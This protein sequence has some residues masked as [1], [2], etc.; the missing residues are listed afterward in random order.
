MFKKIIEFCIDAPMIVLFLAL[1]LGGLGYKMLMEASIDALPD[2]SE[3]Q[4]IVF[5]NW[6]GRSPTDVQDQITYP[7]SVGL[8]GIPMVKQIR[9]IS[10]FGFSQIYVIFE[11][12]VDF[13]WARTRALEKLSSISD[14]LP[15]DAKPVL[16]P[17]ATALGQIY[18]YTVEGPYDNGTLRSIQDFTVRYALQ[19]VHGVSEVASIGGYVREWQVDLDPDA[20]KALGITIAQVQ[21]K[22]RASNLDVGARTLE[23]SGMEYIIRGTGFIE[24]LEDLESIAIREDS[25]TPVLLKNIA[26]VHFGPAFRRG[27]LVDEHREVVGGIV[28][29]RYGANPIEV[30]DGVQDKIARISATLPEG[31]HIKPYYARSKLIYETVDTLSGAIMD[32][33][34]ITIVVIIIFLLHLRSSLIVA[35][36]LP[37]AVL[38]CFIG[39]HYFNVTA[40][41]MSFAGIAIAIGTLV[42][43][44]IIMT[45]NIYSA[46]TRERIKDQGS[47][48]EGESRRK[49]IKDAAAEVAP[50]IFTALGTTIISFV[51]VFFLTGSAYKLFTPLAWTKTLALFAA[52]VVSVTL[53][54]VLCVYFLREPSQESPRRIRTFFRAIGFIGL[55]ALL[56]YVIVL[57][58]S[59]LPE[60]LDGISGAALFVILFALLLFAF[61]WTQTEK[62]IDIED[63]IASRFIIRMYRPSLSF[64]LDRKKLFLV[65]PL[66]IV[67]SGVLIVFGGATLLSPLKS[68]GFSTDKFIATKALQEAFPGIGT[69]F[70]PSLD[71]G[72]LL[73]MPSLLSQASLSESVDVMARQNEAISKV[74]EVLRVVGKAGRATSAL[75]PAPVGMIET[76]VT[77]K[78]RSA[79]REGYTKAKIL[80]ELRIAASVPGVTPSWLQPI[81][82]R[83]VM[84]QSGL[85]ASIG[86]EIYGTDIDELQ[87]VAVKIEELIKTVSGATD[88]T[89]LRIGA[90]P[91]IEFEIDRDAIARYGLSVMDVQNVIE[92]AVGG[93]A[94][95]M[96]LEGLERYPIRLRYERTARSSFDDLGRL[97]VQTSAGASI[98]IA[99]VADIKQVVGPASIRSIDGVLV[100]Y[101][102]FNSK[103]RD[104]DS[105]VADAEKLIRDTIAKEKTAT[106]NERSLNFPEGY[107]FK[108]VGN[109]KNQQEANARFAYLIPICLLSIIF[110]VYLQFRNI[111][112]P[113]MI[114]FGSVPVS[115]SGALI[116]IYFWPFVQDGL[117]ALG[118]VEAPSAGPVYLTVAV[119]VGF[120]ALLGT[121]VDDGVLMSTYI[122]QLFEKKA[123][124]SVR[125]ARELV[126]EAGVR[127]IRPA[128]MT[129]TTTI[130]ALAPVMVSSARG[131]DV[132][133]PMALP[134]FG[135]MI[136]AA[137]VYFVVPVLYCAH[138]E[139][140][141]K[142]KL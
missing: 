12:S 102:M 6:P 89:A 69:Q 112:I 20:M 30:I 50:A 29:M 138:L 79:W 52:G 142:R 59:V 63:N 32:E 135:G 96:S 55:A 11:D 13:Y 113:L 28:I 87:R 103:D 98:P 61:F 15:S 93:K 88:V 116:F 64:C 85:R 26:D 123:P 43:M 33:M 14:T 46:L 47:R 97:Y 70:M 7:L 37:Y 34:L 17:D 134:V 27:A 48:I 136:F 125:E 80:E 99:L 40:N 19:S 115:I 18:W 109:Y 126:L 31:V 76:V 60:L 53:V 118:I 72:D 86:C 51:P 111:F 68:L 107:Y 24:K 73:T 90:R 122:S 101:V 21:M 4:V 57:K 131:A 5:T 129:S 65:L 22:L 120:I 10:G 130:I 45:E 83:I 132:A 106:E 94:L 78:P 9:S 2:I 82:T 66:I 139:Y 54:P 133:I 100:S 71:E 108:W 75:D 1:V 23:N 124:E 127:R 62:L 104:E 8:Q 74:P 137:I 81:E 95:A 44:G 56:A 25:G 39:M 42:D 119:V 92:S 77:L 84:L 114:F 110:L 91:Y 49:V 41:I 38:L 3:N 36:T 141:A 105:V 128:V 67:A 35:S 121:C 140:N 117:F 58:R 16:G